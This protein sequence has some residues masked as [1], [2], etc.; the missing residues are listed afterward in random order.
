MLALDRLMETSFKV[1]DL[2]EHSL[3][4]GPN[5]NDISQVNI[6]LDLARCVG[7]IL[8]PVSVIRLK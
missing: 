6:V 3:G 7:R 8:P 1:V 4:S 2:I 5:F